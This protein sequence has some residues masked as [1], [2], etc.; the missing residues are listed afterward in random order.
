LGQ[1]LLQVGIE[2]LMAVL[3]Q[4]HKKLPRLAGAGGDF[5]LFRG[6]GHGRVPHNALLTVVRDTVLSSTYQNTDSPLLSTLCKSLLKHLISVLGLDEAAP[7]HSTPPPRAAA[8]L[9]S[10]PLAR[11]AA[12]DGAGFRCML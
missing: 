11:L 3:T 5:R 8:P 12:H 7:G 9:A 6:Q 4:K 2:E 1:R 10:C